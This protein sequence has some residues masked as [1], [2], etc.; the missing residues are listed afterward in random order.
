MWSVG[1]VML[2]MATGHPPWPL[3]V[4]LEADE[5]VR[6]VIA[7]TIC[8]FVYCFPPFCAAASGACY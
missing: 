5:L 6:Q 1:C 7:P 3:S 2:E 4:K 8:F